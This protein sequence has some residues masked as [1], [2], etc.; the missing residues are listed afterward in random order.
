VIKNPFRTPP[1]GI[2]WDNPLTRGLKFWFSPARGL[3]LVPRNVMTGPVRISAPRQVG[4]SGTLYTF[5]G[6]PQVI[7]YDVPAVSSINATYMAIGRSYVPN[8]TLQG[9]LFSQGKTGDTNPLF[10]LHQDGSNHWQWQIRNDAVQATN[11]VGTRPMTSAQQVVVGTSV[12]GGLMALYVD[13]SLDNSGTAPADPITVTNIT[14][15]ALLRIGFTLPWIGDSGDAA[16]WN[17]ALSAAEVKLLSSNPYQCLTYKSRKIFFASTAAAV[18]LTGGALDTLL[19]FTETGGGDIGLGGGAQ[20]ILKAFTESGGGTIQS[21]TTNLTGGGADTLRA[22]LERGGGDIGLAGGG[23]QFLRAFQ[24]QGDGVSD[25]P[26]IE[27]AR[28]GGRAWWGYE[29][30]DGSNKPWWYRDLADKAKE[31]ERQR[32]IRIDLGILPKPEA[33]KIAKLTKS[34]DQFIEE[35]PT[36]ET[37]DAYIARASELADELELLI[38]QLQNEDDDEVIMTMS[39][40]F[41]NQRAPVCQMLH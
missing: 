2:N 34:V 41:F 31:L 7:E 22:L 5:D 4:L 27:Q 37:A 29:S 9:T 28:R 24:S 1:L 6:T 19:A 21:N 15:G 17:R 25:A 10:R 20:E 8:N 38:D 11:V 23:T 3:N 13:G 16:I 39:R 36:P 40:F 18:N 32:Q 12:P 33:K 26:P 14:I 30:F 35:M